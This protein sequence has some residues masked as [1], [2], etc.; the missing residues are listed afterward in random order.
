MTRL[1]ASVRP[2]WP[3]LRTA[4]TLGTRV[5]APA[6]KGLSRVR[7]DYLPRSAVATLEAAATASGGRFCVARPV[8][9]VERPLPEGRPPLHAAFVDNRVETIDRVGVGELPGGRVLGRHHAVITRTGDFVEEVSWYFNT[10]RPSEHPLYL[11]PFPPAPVDVPGRL[12]VLA[13]RGD[14]IYYHFL[15][16]VLPRLGVLDQCPDVEPPD[17]WYVPANLS[18]Q[19]Q[20]LDLIGIDADERIDSSEVP[21]VRAECL[22]VPGLPGSN[23]QNR[24]W[25]VAFLRERLLPPGVTRIPGRNLFITRGAA[26]YNRIV[27][28]EEAVLEALA[29]RGFDRVDPG[30]MSVADQIRAFAEADVIVSPHGSALT[31][32]V[33]CSPGSCLVE[34]FP[35]GHIVPDYWKMACGV[36][37]LEYR[38]LAGADA[39]ERCNRSRMLVTDV[40]VDVDALRDTLKE[41]GH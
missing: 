5:V 30:E 26:R 9:Q 21:H 41:I 17:R 22:V 18:F 24:A 25:V 7:G 10:S 19:R 16:D 15:I 31:N 28:N 11:H 32:I 34:L 33:F 6:T 39:T 13:S 20:L 8:E 14:R 35:R 37:G 29:G 27:R 4:Y 36:P 38:Y 3:Q 40:L 12:G 23:V 2:L 1:P